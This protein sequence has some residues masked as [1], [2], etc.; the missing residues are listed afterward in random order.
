M[1]PMLMLASIL[2]L[3]FA[4]RTTY[5]MV[6]RSWNKNRKANTIFSPEELAR[7]NG[8]KSSEPILLAVMGSVYDVSR[9]RRFYGT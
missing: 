1:L 6:Q 4:A 5:R 7:Y 2:M 8:I 3:S 9:G